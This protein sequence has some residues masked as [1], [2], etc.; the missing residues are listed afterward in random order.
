ML[1]DQPVI[2]H[3]LE[4]K[5]PVTLP[6]SKMFLLNSP[7]SGVEGK[8][9]V[10]DDRCQ[11]FVRLSVLD[12][13]WISFEETLHGSVGFRLDFIKGGA[14]CSGGDFFKETGSF[15]FQPIVAISLSS[16]LS[17]LVTAVTYVGMFRKLV[18]SFARVTFTVLCWQ[19]LGEHEPGV[20]REF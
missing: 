7:I 19:I 11:S 4:A 6:V 20:C 12:L 10:F 5:E 17:N 2:R 1:E 13:I 14:A 16:P 9:Q 8:G 18:V 15:L 3:R